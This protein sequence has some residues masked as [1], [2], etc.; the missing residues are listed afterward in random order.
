MAGRVVVE[1]RASSNAPRDIVWAVL[2]DGRSWADWGEWSWTRY[3]EEGDPAPDGVGAVRRFRRAPVTSVERVELFEPPS[4][5][6]YELLSGLPLRDYH[7]VVTLTD[8]SAGSGTDLH[9][10]SEFTPKVPGS[11]WFWKAFLG[12][13]LADVGRGICTEAERRSA[14]A[15]SAAAP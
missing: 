4:R 2:A 9:W 15:T 10:R 11:G 1:A 12:K 14:A 5:F 7:A 6:G 3:D 13:V 8:S